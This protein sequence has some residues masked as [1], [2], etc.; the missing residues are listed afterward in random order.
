LDSEVDLVQPDVFVISGFQLMNQREK[1]LI[2]GT[3]SMLSE[4]IVL[5]KQA[6]P[7]LKFHFEMGAFSDRELMR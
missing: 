5:M 7:G 1:E 3:L 6:M 2:S 4:K